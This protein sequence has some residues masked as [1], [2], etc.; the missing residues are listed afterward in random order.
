MSPASG[1]RSQ[2]GMLDEALH[3]EWLRSE[4]NPMG[5]RVIFFL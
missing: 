5:L 3:G 1:A 4:T 2:R